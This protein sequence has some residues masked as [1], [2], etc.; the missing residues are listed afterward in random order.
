MV[1]NKNDYTKS[2]SVSDG[3]KSEVLKVLKKV[4]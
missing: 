3:I 2:T 4:L 1:V